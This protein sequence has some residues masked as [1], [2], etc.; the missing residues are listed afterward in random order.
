M[1]KNAKSWEEI[2]RKEVFSKYGKKMDSIMFKMPD[3]KEEEYI[4]KNEIPTV[5]I[6]AL[7]KDKQVIITKQFRPGPMKIIFELPGG[8]ID[9]DEDPIKAAE[10][11]LLEETGYKGDLELVVI[12]NDCGYSTR[13][14]HCFVATNCTK[15]SEQKLDDTEWI[16]LDL[17]Y[18]KEFRK[19]LKSGQMSDT[20]TGYFGLDYLGLL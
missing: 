17:M 4:V 12:A 9:E 11:E 10:R 18:L 6:L 19:I 2:S 15:V 14:R 20:E 1:N 8:G 3:G 16:D 7:T 5:S 13:K